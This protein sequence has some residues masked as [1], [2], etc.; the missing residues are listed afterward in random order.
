M[1]TLDAVLEVLTWTAIPAG[2]LLLLA[3]TVMRVV[4]GTWTLTPVLLDDAPQGRVARWFGDDGRVG[5]ARL[6]PEQAHALAGQDAA[7]VFTRSG[8]TDRIR[9]TPRSPA[10][11]GVTLLAAGLLRFGA[12]S[13]LSSLVLLFVR[14]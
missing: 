13:W 4:D 1:D 5:E 10:V 2:L 9:L 12:A 11:R 3:A 14:G 6:S 8:V 7:D